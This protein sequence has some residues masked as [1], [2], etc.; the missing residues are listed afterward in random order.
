[1]N[2]KFTILIPFLNENKSLELCLNYLYDTFSN[3]VNLN[4]DVVVCSHEATSYEKK[5][6]NNFL[7]KN[8]F[9]FIEQYSEEKS[10]GSTISLALK[11]TNSIYTLIMPVDI[12][13]PK[14]TILSFQKEV[15]DNARYTYGGFYKKYSQSSVLISLY[16]FLQNQINSKFL[17]NLVWTNCIFIKND[18]NITIPQTGFLED[19]TLSDELKSHGNWKL[20][21]KPIVVSMRKYTNDGI[22]NRILGNILILL[23]HR[24]RILSIKSLHILYSKGFFYFLKAKL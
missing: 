11:K 10:I 8:N 6:I 3:I 2:S 13:I 15:L 23:L 1:M 7:K 22:I 4:F 12:K 16:T 17:K 5:I 24:M 21:N 14:E 9:S 18:N 20:M 19:I